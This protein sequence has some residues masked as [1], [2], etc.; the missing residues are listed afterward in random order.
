VGP[1]TDSAE[2]GPDAGRPNWGQRIPLADGTELAASV[3][4]P[5][6]DGPSPAL[7]SYLPY[8]KDDLLGI[9]FDRRAGEHFVANGYATVLADLRGLGSSS[10]RALD[11]FDPQDWRDGAAIVE[12]VAAQEWCDGNVGMWGLSYGGIT[13]MGTATEAPRHLRAIV[14]MMGLT[15]AYTDYFFPGGCR[16]MLGVS[17]V[18]GAFMVAMQLL[19]PMYMDPGGRS[20]QRWRERLEALPDPYLLA[21]E[22]HPEHDRFW[23]ERIIDPA[24]IEVPSL[25]IGGW[26]DIFPA[27]ML[28]AFEA[29]SGPRELLMGPWT[30]LHPEESGFEAIDHLAEMVAWWDRW[31]RPGDG[32]AAPTALP[33]SFFSQGEDRWLQSE[34]WPPAGAAESTLWLAPGNALE[35]REAASEEYVHSVDPTIGTAAGV[36]DVFG[37]DVG[38]PIDQGPDDLR[39]LTFTGPPLEHSLRIA[40]T[41][42]ATLD[43]SIE[44]GEDLHLVAK[45][46]DV[47]AD[48]SSTLITSGWLNAGG[49]E[50]ACQVDL[51]PTAYALAAG[52][53]LRLTVAGAD[54][55][56][57][58]PT[59]RNPTF[60]LRC[61]GPGGSRLRLP[62]LPDGEA[63]EFSPPPPPADAGVVA[64]VLDH[65]P[66]W[67]VER[68]EVAGE[69]AVANGVQI[70]F[71]TPSGSARVIFDHT[72]RASVRRD[73]PDGA[74]VLG[75]TRISADLTSGGRV[76][77][78]TSTLAT[79]SGSS[80]HG[81]VL[82]DGV[83]VFER[84]WRARRRHGGDPGASQ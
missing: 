56:R 52:H 43:V 76:E 82:L 5:A 12:W 64:G 42:V 79:Q 75:E 73:R 11:A 41:P 34:S 37:L 60:R 66:R 32:A 29:A 23:T 57:I 81:R 74:R 48:G 33:V 68:D 28:A 38:K 78:E 35:A 67:R 51:Y 21:W 65:A 58:W 4:L 26:R 80:A 49:A 18:W 62:V 47:A 50:A 46:C 2:G 69:V 63:S 8:H 7:V 44:E 1:D 61:G 31:L 70:V 14:P 10:G 59:R 54:F 15:D 24:K 25:F 27:P 19:P 13:T 16:N 84:T 36:W 20:W 72:G 40:G 22:D 6:G 45:L 30:H 83:E 3:S 77:V 39:S 9:S 55:P 71:D 17:G 53:R